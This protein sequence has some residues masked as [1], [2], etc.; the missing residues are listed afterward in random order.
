M[1]LPQLWIVTIPFAPYFLAGWS[2]IIAM[3]WLSG[4]LVDV[5]DRVD[6]HLRLV[7]KCGYLFC[8]ILV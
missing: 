3:Y 1:A 7:R 5:A 2:N 4:G 8:T 6:E